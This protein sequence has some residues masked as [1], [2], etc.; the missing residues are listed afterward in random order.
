MHYVIDISYT[1][2]HAKYRAGLQHC[3]AYDHQNI[4]FCSLICLISL[5]LLYIYAYISCH[6]FLP[7]SVM[8]SAVTASR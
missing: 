3:T 8:F 2:M 7:N 6:G 5:G 1:D 4:F